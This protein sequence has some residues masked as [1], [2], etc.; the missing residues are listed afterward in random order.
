VSVSVDG[1]SSSD[2]FSDDDLF[3]S[4][5]KDGTSTNNRTNFPTLSDNDNSFKL[6][7]GKLTYLNYNIGKFDANGLLVIKFSNNVTVPDNYTGLID[8]IIQIKVDNNEDV[9]II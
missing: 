3:Y 5:E 9:N 8:K 6:T 4:T 1:D 2:D 7:L